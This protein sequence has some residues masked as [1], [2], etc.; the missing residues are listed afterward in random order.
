SVAEAVRDFINY[1]GRKA[2]WSHMRAILVGEELARQG[3]NT[4]VDFF[5][6]D[7]ESRL[8]TPVLITKGEAKNY[9]E[10]RPY[11]ENTIAQQIRKLQQMSAKYTGITQNSN[12]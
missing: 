3:F 7:S 6:R 5:Y 4:F 9:L 10:V 11:I 1:L 8:T 2:Q 12:L